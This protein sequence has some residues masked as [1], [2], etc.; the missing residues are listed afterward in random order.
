MWSQ[1]SQNVCFGPSKIDFGEKL[2]KRV[3]NVLEV[4]AGVTGL[5]LSPKI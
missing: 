4:G 3:L 2:T 1:T 5:G